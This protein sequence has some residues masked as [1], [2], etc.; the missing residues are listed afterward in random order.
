MLRK[1]GF[2]KAKL[3]KIAFQDIL[4]LD[5]CCARYAHQVQKGRFFYPS[6]SEWNRG[7]AVFGISETTGLFLFDRV[8]PAKGLKFGG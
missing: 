5:P 1:S 6:E 2:Q 3:R 7:P 8:R 4:Q